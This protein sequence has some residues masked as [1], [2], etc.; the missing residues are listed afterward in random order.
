[1]TCDEKWLYKINQTLNKDSLHLGKPVGLVTLTNKKVFIC[2]WQDC[3]GILYQEI[4]KNIQTIYNALGINRRLNVHNVISK[5]RRNEFR[6]MEFSITKITPT[7]TSLH[8]GHL[9]TLRA[10]VRFHATSTT[11]LCRG[12]YRFLSL[13]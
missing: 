8:G 7:T 11:Q 1:M 2:I 6:R 9:N 4:F 5:R 12:P 10:R 13:F 3:R